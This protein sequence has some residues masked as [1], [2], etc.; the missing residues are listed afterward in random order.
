[1]NRQYL[2]KLSASIFSLLV[3]AFSFG[4]SGTTPVKAATPLNITTLGTYTSMSPIGI[5]LSPVLNKLIESGGY[6]TGLPNNFNQIDLTTGTSTPFSTVSGWTDEDYFAIADSN[7][8]AAGFVPGTIYS[9]TG[10]AGQIAK[11]SPDGSTVTNPWVTLPGETMTLRGSVAFDQVGTFNYNLLVTASNDSFAPSTIW[12]VTSTG[13]ATKLV[14]LPIVSE[15]LVVIPNQSTNYGPWAGKLLVGDELDHSIYAVAPNGTFQVYSGLGVSPESL[16]VV[17]PGGTL[18]A[19]NYN[20][21]TGDRILTASSTD[22]SSAGMINDVIEADEFPGVLHDIHWNGTSFVTTSV[23]TASQ[24]EQIIVTL[25]SATV[26]PSGNGCAFYQDNGNDKC[27]ID[28]DQGKGD[29]IHN[30]G[31]DAPPVVIKFG[32]AH[33][34]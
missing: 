29:D 14:T 33:H 24:F 3:I 27:R 1:M 2:I 6:P 22:L 30:S 12:E 7:N 18:Y 21:G 16:A 31:N 19:V 26:P 8:I 11:I 10:A 15:G 13:V 28:K 4:L 17:N 32:S 25:P 9:G 34:P 20:S 5:G 23:G